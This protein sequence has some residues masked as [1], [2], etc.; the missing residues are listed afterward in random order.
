MFRSIVV[1]LDGSELAESALPYAVQLARAADGALTLVRVAIA[2]PP[3][4]LDGADWEFEQAQAVQEAEAYLSATAD[5]LA[6]RVP[7][8]TSVTYGRAPQ[9]IL[10]S[11]EQIGADAIVMAT[12]GR[13]GLPHLVHG[14]VAEALLATSPVPVLL[15]HA[16]PGE[17]PA[18]PFDPASAR[19]A[20][21]LD[22][23]EFAESALHTA[24][25]LVGPRGELVLVCIVEPPEH[26]EYDET[27]RVVVAYLDQQEEV[28]T[29]AGRDYLFKI[30]IEIGRQYP[31]VQISQDV[32]CGD[33]SSGII[34][35]A[36]DKSIDLI[37]MST[38]GRTGV[39]RAVLGSVAGEV[40]VNGT[41]PVL[42][43]GP[44][45]ASAA[46][47]GAMSRGV[48]SPA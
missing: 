48:A 34:A 46:R 29:R 39:S 19:I 44:H 3:A 24:A 6:A 28:R 38:H 25:G 12:H 16:R 41:M 18:A 43:V 13:T 33:A 37:V 5:K 26:V 36:I 9:H 32:R 2:P 20:V 35:A 31:G 14:S 1:P 7:V 42:L 4:R 10:E 27:G 45:Q 17:A 30:A 11:V 21:P 8:T 15:V 47:S 22:G 23:S 40:V